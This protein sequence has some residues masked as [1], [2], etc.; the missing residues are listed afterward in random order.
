M[1]GKSGKSESPVCTYDFRL[2]K[3]GSD[4]D[5]IKSALN[6]FCKKWVFQ[7]EKGNKTGY[8]HY[9]GRFSLKTKMHKHVILKKFQ[10]VGFNPNYLEKT[11]KE[12]QK[13]DFYVTK[14]DTRTNGPW[15]D[16]DVETFIPFQFNFKIENL[17]PFQKSIFESINIKDSRSIN[18]VYCKD[19]CTGKTTIGMF[20]KLFSNGYYL[21]PLNDPKELIQ[22]LCDQCVSKKDR[23]PNPIIIDLPRS[24]N[25]DN[26]NGIW[27]AVEQIKNG[28]L[29]DVRY[30]YKEWL[31]NSPVVWVFTNAIPDMKALSNDRWKLWTIN[32]SNKLIVFNEADTNSAEL[33]LPTANKKKVNFI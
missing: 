26:L 2:S 32:K 16:N 28:I 27:N 7:E 13:N 18:V 3:E 17:L 1:S 31:I 29:Y 14:D 25:K 24:M 19:G 22:M 11:S 9:Q 33:N 21:A 20:C 23:S 6:Q 10:D 4:F 12:N 8:E 15:K 5:K 30:H